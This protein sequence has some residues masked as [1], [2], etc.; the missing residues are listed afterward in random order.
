MAAGMPKDAGAL[1]ATV[2]AFAS[3]GVDEL[4]FVP[5]NGDLGQLD[6]LIEGIGGTTA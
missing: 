1:K 5:T 6:L 4:F 3:V 2:E